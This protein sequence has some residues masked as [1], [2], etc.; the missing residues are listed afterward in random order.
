MKDE[1]MNKFDLI[2]FAKTKVQKPAKSTR[3]TYFHTVFSLYQNRVHM[4]LVIFF[5]LLPATFYVYF[6]RVSCVTYPS[7]WMYYLL[8]QQ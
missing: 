4:Q 5:I 8:Q 2:W 6:M 3:Y 1:R 7:L